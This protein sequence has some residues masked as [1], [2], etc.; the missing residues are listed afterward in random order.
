MK[1]KSIFLI[2][3]CS[4]ISCIKIHAQDKCPTEDLKIIR[5]SQ[6]D[7]FLIL[8]PDCNTVTNSISIGG[9]DITSLEALK[10]IHSIYNLLISKTNITSLHGLD[11]LK[12]CSATFII[13]ANNL[14]TD[15]KP[16]KNLHYA[17]LVNISYNDLIVDYSGLSGDS[18]NNILIYGN[19]KIKNLKGLN[20]SYCTR[21]SINDT[22]LNSL[23]GHEILNLKSLYVSNINTLDSIYF[24]NIYSVQIEVCPHLNSII[25]LNSLTS[26][27]GLIIMGTVNLKDCSTELIC[28]KI[29]DPDFILN[30]GFN[31]KGC[32]TKEEVRAGCVSDT[33]NI[34]DKQQINIYPQP[35][36]SDML[37]VTGLTDTADYQISNLQGQLVQ[38]G[39]VSNSVDISRLLPGFYILQLYQEHKNNAVKSF[40]VVRL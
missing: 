12:R 21:L 2:V 11:S 24:D 39:E 37:F 15:L 1:I 34:P 3:F 29:D 35:I 18:L 20:S 40:K 25:P 22:N 31:S 32:N 9:P 28:S 38:K 7:S 33:G 4:L 8:Y 23:A 5:Q 36:Y 14:L 13:S 27:K 26:L 30:L 17:K 16:L 10:N 6:L 19:K